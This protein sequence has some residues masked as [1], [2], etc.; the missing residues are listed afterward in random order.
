MTTYSPE[1]GGRVVL[2]T[3]AARGQG[4][5]IAER[6]VSAGASVVAGDVL[7]AVHELAATYPESVLAV[8]L[9]VTRAESWTALLER[10]IDRFDRLDGLVNNAGVL[11]KEPLARETAADFER[12]WAIN[13][14][15][16]F[17]GMQAC[18]PHLKAAGPGSSIVNTLSTVATHVIA[19]YASY[20]SSKWALRGLTKVAAL[21]LA[22]E[23]VRVNAI[24]PGPILTPMVV[25]SD[26]PAAAARLASTPVGRAGTPE[27]V[28]ELVLF[29]L[30]DQSSFITGAE[31]AIDGGQ[32]AGILPN[33][34]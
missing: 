11:R 21:E 27:E 8:D 3:G 33:R 22:A 28:A 20:G 25:T 2:V 16:S 9:D 7:P 18:L 26:D 10:A 23:G 4:R 14:L 29:L 5:S 1:L 15:G 17:L 32:S 13:C 6:L 12:V 30:S 19:G 31:I 24:L 34:I